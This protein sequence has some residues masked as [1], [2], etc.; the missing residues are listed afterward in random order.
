MPRGAVLTGA[1]RNLVLGSFPEQ[2]EDGKA[3]FFHP[4]QCPSVSEWVVAVSPGLCPA[5]HSGGVV[6][7]STVAD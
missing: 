3:A 6:P 1:T 4:S 2:S 7:S 5:S